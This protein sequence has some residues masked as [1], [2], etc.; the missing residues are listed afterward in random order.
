MIRGKRR[1]KRRDVGE[2]WGG[3]KMR[4]KR[5]GPVKRAGFELISI[6]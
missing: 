4:R 5:G 6:R 2:D 1:E 3:V